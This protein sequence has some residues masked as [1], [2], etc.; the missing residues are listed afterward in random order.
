MPSKEIGDLPPATT[1]LAGNELVHIVQG[2][3]SRN[4]P[5]EALADAIS[6]TVPARFRGFRATNDSSQSISATTLT[7]IAVEFELFD[8]EAAVDV[9]RF[10]VPSSLNGK[11]M[12]FFAGVLFD[13]VEEFD[14]YIEVSDDSGASWAEVAHQAQGGETA[15]IVASGPV[16]LNTG[17]IYR[18]TI[19]TADAA[20]ILEDERVFFSGVVLESTNNSVQIINDGT[21]ARTLTDI[22]FVGTRII[23]MTSGSAQTVTIDTGLI[24]DQ[25]VTIVQRGTG[26]ITYGGTAT[27]NSKGGNL[28]S[29]GRYG[30]VTIIPEG[31][32][33]YTLIGD[34]TA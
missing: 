14:F 9:S 4:A 16:L 28:K 30:A 21:G 20:L 23:M 13:A 8:T 15:T 1:P 19:Y 11:Y 29:N 6:G 7:E 32:N 2:G 24:G 33:V 22:D 25:P 34:L 18:I 10:E 26:Q 3:N 5:M 12:A 27:L 17:D 31:S